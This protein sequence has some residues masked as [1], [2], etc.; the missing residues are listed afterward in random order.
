MTLETM[1]LEAL[2]GGRTLMSIQSIYQSVI[3]RDSVLQSGMEGGANDT[4]NRLE[5]LIEKM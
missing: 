5:E 2:P 3:D 1:K 4:Y